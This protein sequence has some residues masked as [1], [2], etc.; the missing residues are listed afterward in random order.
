MSSHGSKNKFDFGL[1]GPNKKWTNNNCDLNGPT[2]KNSWEGLKG[3]FS[4]IAYVGCW[5]SR[6][7]YSTH[8]WIAK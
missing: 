4:Q 5:Q 1:N 7:M 8:K 2:P 3:C 6:H